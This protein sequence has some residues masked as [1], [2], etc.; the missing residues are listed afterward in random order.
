MS[1]NCDGINRGV[2]CV[3]AY[4]EQEFIRDGV[5]TEVTPSLRKG[6]CLSTL[7]RSKKGVGGV[8]W[9]RCLRQRKG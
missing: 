5:N 3:S 4:D 8:S 6:H 9:S 2:V 7:S 1:G